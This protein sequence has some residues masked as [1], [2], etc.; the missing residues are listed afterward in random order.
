[1]I[2]GLARVG[3]GVSGL[4]VLE[5]RGRRSGEVRRVAVA[6]LPFAGSRYLVAP[7]GETHWVRNLRAARAGELVLGRRRER[8]RAVEL[9][10]SEKEPVLRE[11]VRRWKFEVG[12]FF[13][14]VDAGSEAGEFTRIAPDH[15]VFRIDD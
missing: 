2:R 1:M 8:F 11:Y 14:G 12:R 4:H 7:R 15:P 6:V 5:V 3:I 10:D 13:D 9:P